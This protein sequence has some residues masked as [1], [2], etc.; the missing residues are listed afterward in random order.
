MDIDVNANDALNISAA[1]ESVQRQQE[2]PGVPQTH[3][4]THA[5]TETETQGI[6]GVQEGDRRRT[7]R[8]IAFRFLR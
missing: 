2:M 1:L 7:F 6:S 3:T 4:H 8:A 5:K